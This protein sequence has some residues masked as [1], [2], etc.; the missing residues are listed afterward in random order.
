MNFSR[1]CGHRLDLAIRLN[2]EIP[3]SVIHYRPIGIIHSPF[4]TPE[5]TPIQPSGA[6]GI[7]A[8]IL[9]F[10]EFSEGLADL[11]GFSHIFLVYHFHLSKKFSLRV[12]PFL[13]TVDR[14]VFATRAPARPNPIGISVVRL[15]GMENDRLRVLDIDVVDGTPLLDIKPYVPEFDVRQVD[16]IGWI[17]NKTKT[18]HETRDNGR[19]SDR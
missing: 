1:S 11:E 13:D 15:A 2:Q 19:F 5:G 18:I 6:R 4:D 16:K 10:P 3:M 12:K 17:A 14:G 7:V 8:E 9:I